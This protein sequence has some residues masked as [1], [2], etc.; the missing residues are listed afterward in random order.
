MI[1]PG[2]MFEDLPE[3]ERKRLNMAA[4]SC[5]LKTPDHPGV[6][7]NP[8]DW[9]CAPTI[10]TVNGPGDYKF[11]DDPSVAEHVECLKRTLESKPE[12]KEPADEDAQPEPGG[13]H[14]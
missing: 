10:M 11:S 6:L 4:V 9:M 13:N 3:D 1:K 2:E 8:L 12:E 14:R 7:K 5:G